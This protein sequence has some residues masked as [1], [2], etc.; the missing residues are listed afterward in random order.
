[1]VRLH[2]ILLSFSGLLKG[3]FKL[4]PL[5]S[6]TI[7]QFSECFK[8][9]TIPHHRII[10]SDFNTQ[11]CCLSTLILSSVYGNCCHLPASETVYHTIWRLFFKR[12]PP[13]ATISMPAASPTT[14]TTTPNAI[15]IAPEVFIVLYAFS[16]VITPFLI[17]QLIIAII[18]TRRYISGND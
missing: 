13:E 15:L 10:L 8:N 5:L 11:L 16:I 4:S 9:S 3:E 14:R 12:H 2:P 17:L 18:I 7:R 6:R 1:M